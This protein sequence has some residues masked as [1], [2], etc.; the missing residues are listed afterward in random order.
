MA[1]F[2]YEVR[3]TKEIGEKEFRYYATQCE[4]EHI[5]ANEYVKKYFKDIFDADIKN[6][7]HSEELIAEFAHYIKPYTDPAW[8]NYIEIKDIPYGT[9]FSREPGETNSKYIFLMQTPNDKREDKL[10][11]MTNTGFP[12]FVN[13]FTQRCYIVPEETIAKLKAR[14]KGTAW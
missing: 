3:K 6:V 10:I 12:I 2:T 14:S 4:S 9:Y 1:E 8:K 7:K 11:V 13:N 5:S